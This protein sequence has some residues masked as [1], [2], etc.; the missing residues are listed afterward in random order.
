MGFLKAKS[1]FKDEIYNLLN[2]YDLSK[3]RF[4]LDEQYFDFLD[5]REFSEF[6]VNLLQKIARFRDQKYYFK[7][8]RV[9][10][11]E[12]YRLDFFSEYN[13]FIEKI[14]LTF[15]L[16]ITKEKHQ[17]WSDIIYEIFDHFEDLTLYP[18]LF[19][20]LS[21]VFDKLKNHNKRAYI[22]LL[23]LRKIRHSDII[24]KQYEDLFQILKRILTQ[25]ENIENLHDLVY[26]YIMLLLELNETPFLKE[27]SETL[28]K[29]LVKIID[30]LNPDSQKDIKTFNFLLRHILK[31]ED[32]IIR[33]YLVE[34]LKTTSNYN[35]FK[36]YLWFSSM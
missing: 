18:M 30:S 36:E 35:F 6:S 27:V 26:I 25:I 11:F 10:F 23:I 4:L 14:I 12:L 3:I 24:N 1:Y 34:A 22:F 31:L 17:E 32:K 2:K 33:S 7:L 20:K 16:Q 21:T 13:P 19:S 28:K 29:I 15:F 8:I 9:L 5:K